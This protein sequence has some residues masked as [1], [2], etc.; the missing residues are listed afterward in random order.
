MNQETSHRVAVTQLTQSRLLGGRPTEGIPSLGTLYQW[1]TDF[2]TSVFLPVM[3]YGARTDKLE[4]LW[5]LRS[6]NALIISHVAQEGSV[7]HSMD[8]VLA[9]MSAW[10]SGLLFLCAFDIRR[11]TRAFAYLASAMPSAWHAAMYEQGDTAHAYTEMLH[12]L[13]RAVFGGDVIGEALNGAQYFLTHVDADAL[14]QYTGSCYLEIQKG[15]QRGRPRWPFRLAG[16]LQNT[17]STQCRD[18]NMPRYV[19]WRS[20]GADGVCGFPVYMASM[21]VAFSRE[22]YLI[23]SRFSNIQPNPPPAYTRHKKRS[24]RKRPLQ[25]HRRAQKRAAGITSKVA[26]VNRNLSVIPQAARVLPLPQLGANTRPDL[27][28]PRAYRNTVQQRSA[29]SKTIAGPINITAPGNEF[30]VAQYAGQPGTRL[31]EISKRMTDERVLLTAVR[32]QK[33]GGPYRQ[34]QATRKMHNLARA[35]NLPPPRTYA[36]KIRRSFFWLAGIV[37]RVVGTMLRAA[38][39]D[40]PA[41][42]SFTRAHTRV[43]P[44]RDHYHSQS[45]V[46]EYAASA[47]YNHKLMIHVPQFM[48]DTATARFPATVVRENWDTVVTPSRQ[49]IT[50]ELRAALMGWVR[51]FRLHYNARAVARAMQPLEAALKYF[52]ATPDRA[53]PEEFQPQGDFN[54]KFWG[55]AMVGKVDHDVRCL[56]QRPLFN[57]HC[58]LRKLYTQDTVTFKV[59][60]WTIKRTLAFMRH[61]YHVEYPGRF[62]VPSRWSEDSIPRGIARTKAKC[63]GPDGLACDRPGHIHERIIVNTS[64][65][66]NRRN[67]KIFTRAWQ[68]AKQSDPLENCEV[69]SPVDM[70]AQHRASRDQLIA[71]PGFEKE[72][73]ACEGEKDDFTL[74]RFDC[75]SLYTHADMITLR[76]TEAPACLE[77]VA[78]RWKRRTITVQEARQ[79]RG[80]IGGVSPASW[81]RRVVTHREMLQFLVYMTRMNMFMLGRGADATIIF[82]KLGCAMGGRYSKMA[83]SL[84]LG[85]GEGRLL[86]D[87]QR[88]LAEKFIRPGMDIHQVISMLRIVDDGGV[89]SKLLCLKCCERFVRLAWGLDQLVSCEEAGREIKF[90]DCIEY[91]AHGQ[92]HLAPHWH[93]TLIGKQWTRRTTRYTPYDRTFNPIAYVRSLALGR[94]HRLTQIG[95]I[96]DATYLRGLVD[97]TLELTGSDNRYPWHIIRRALYGI[98][99]R[100]AAPALRAIITMLRSFEAHEPSANN[101]EQAGAMFDF[102]SAAQ[103]ALVLPHPI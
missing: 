103:T 58:T 75:G 18:A 80:R 13:S 96:G 87:T 46:G 77:R 59:S 34:Q 95:P 17:V 43:T 71:I 64:G 16:H 2:Q 8:P 72:C 70:T 27:N 44:G 47:S 51:H 48:I 86:N 90:G 83:T 68:L 82:Q 66:P 50:K 35:R 19:L 85:G 38:E 14:N 24:G 93:N 37:S 5:L 20:L 100:P 88:L 94:L 21:A 62:R 76:N 74:A 91:Y 101:L 54:N 67:D 40:D 29:E 69:W 81:A 56:I 6:A 79:V 12:M 28:L 36:I 99:V 73:F 102:Y 65:L 52:P 26:P 23:K 31:D 84:L 97:L 39:T 10:L 53:H 60:D 1:C 32:I 63:L 30:L 98:K 33:V 89:A 11:Q 15:A 4:I 78:R 45:V 22:M 3:I 9:G 7:F 55:Q 41:L 49:E 61:V 25:S 42:T 57:Y 92:F